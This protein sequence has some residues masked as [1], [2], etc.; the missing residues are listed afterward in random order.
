MGEVDLKVGG[1]DMWWRKGGM[2]EEGREGRKG[3]W[4][5]KGGKEGRG[6]GGEREGRK[7]GGVVEEGREGRKGVWWRKGGKEGRGQGGGIR[8]RWR[9]RGVVEE[10]GVVEGRGCDG[11]LDVTHILC[12]KVVILLL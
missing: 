3:V 6:C 11:K 8:M 5:I 10:G 1:L 4:W 2:V 7:E 9:E 12:K